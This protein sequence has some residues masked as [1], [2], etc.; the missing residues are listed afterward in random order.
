MVVHS[1][2][3]TEQREYM[4]ERLSLSFTVRSN[5]IPSPP[6]Y[7]TKFGYVSWESYYNL[8]Y[9][10]RLLPPIPENCPLPMG[11]KGET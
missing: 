7:N 10:T 5:L 3:G 9:Y 11:T 8:S 2:W 4:K 6:T 1:F